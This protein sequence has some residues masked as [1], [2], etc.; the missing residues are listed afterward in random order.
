MCGMAI[1]VELTLRLQNS[2]GTAAKICGYLSSER[3]NI[4][5]FQL[6]SV[7]ILRLIVDNPVHAAALLREQKVQVEE[8]DVLYTTLPNDPG[9]LNRLAR[10]LAEAK[11]NVEYLYCTAVES[12]PMA[13]VVIG[14]PDAQKASQASGI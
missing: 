11:V 8:R 1:R 7:G 14:V 5:A 6:E 4:L 9:A 10:L 13:A 2:P 12:T 3:V